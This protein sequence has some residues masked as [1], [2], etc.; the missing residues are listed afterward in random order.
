MTAHTTPMT[1]RRALRGILNNEPG[2][3]ARSQ[4][5]RIMQALATIGPCTTAE[6][7]RWLDCP[8]AGARLTELRAQGY[9]IE[10]HWRTDHT[11]AGEPHRF[12]LYVLAPMK[13][14]QAVLQAS[15]PPSNG[16]IETLPP[17]DGVSKRYPTGQGATH[18]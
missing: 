14:M 4:R 16:G 9:Q 17:L 12:A 10:T 13:K 5:N 1:K 8:R 11:E 18:V 7:V 15:T 6:M 2:N 3:S